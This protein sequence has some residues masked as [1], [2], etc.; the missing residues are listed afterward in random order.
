[1]IYTEIMIKNLFFSLGLLLM[2]GPAFSESAGRAVN[3]LIYS[4]VPDMSMVRVGD[5]Y[6]MSSTTMHMVPGVPIM[7]SKD[8]SNW[9]LAGY[10]YDTLT[11]SLATMNLEDGKNTYG[12]GSWASCIRYHNGKY[13]VSTFAQTTNKTYFFITDNPEKGPW[14]RIEFSPSYHDMNFFFDEDG[15]KYMIYGNGKLVM[16]ELKDDLSGI[17]P[18]TKHVLIENA[19][20]PAGD[21]IMLGS[22][23][24]Q[25][26][27]VNGKYYL[28]NIV[29]P[30]NEMRTVVVHRADKITG[31][32]E[33][34]VV[35]QDKGIAQGG[36]V[37]TPD[38][39]WFAY[40][41]QDCGAVGRIP[42]LVPMEWKDGWPVIGVNGKAPEY[43]DLPAS[44]GLDPGIVC[45]DD[46][47]RKSGERA[48]P[49]TW[50]WNHNPD[51]SLWSVSDRKGYLRL[52][53]GSVTNSILQ[54]KNTLTQRTFGPVSSATT[55]VDVSA[56]KDGDY[57]GLSLFQKKYGYVAVK[58]VDNKRYI[59][60]EDASGNEPVEVACIPCKSDKVYFKAECDFRNRTDK[61]YF[62]YSL[63]GKKWTEIGSVVKMQYTMPHFMGY[64]FGLFNYATK[65][66]GG[67]VDFDFFKIDDS[68]SR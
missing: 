11:D 65:E 10:A 38:G 57:A 16:A 15:K 1:M 44:K 3:P 50:Q 45:S 28:F 41:F 4:D 21:N 13:Y 42:Y 8:L 5:T 46:F 61:G 7:K 66:T 9:E 51:N 18:E 37:D 49:L 12:Q 14:K 32:Y 24:S 6:Y 47:S 59:V 43:L 19:S 68:I 52:T 27:K 39:R 64:R 67:Y 25:L 54:A 36:I 62:Y 23:G 34:R 33:G 58:K 20:A 35:F 29:W 55:C 53:T 31:P 30:R 60:M 22:E 48:L 17:L 63:D 56:M 2:S 40:L 26:F